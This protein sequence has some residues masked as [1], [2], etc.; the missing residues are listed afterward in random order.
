[1]IFAQNDLPGRTMN[2]WDSSEHWIKCLPLFGFVFV[3]TISPSCSATRERSVVTLLLPDS[4]SGDFRCVRRVFLSG[5]NWERRQQQQHVI[6]IWKEIRS[7]MDLSEVSL[8]IFSELSPPQSHRLSVFTNRR[9]KNAFI[10]RR[11]EVQWYTLT[12]QVDRTSM[13]LFNFTFRDNFTFASTSHDL[14]SGGQWRTEQ[15]CRACH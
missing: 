13:I 7:A 9:K 2:H 6:L 1:M 12:Y 8:G 14:S 10:R 15:M 3:F 5:I 4:I 11:W